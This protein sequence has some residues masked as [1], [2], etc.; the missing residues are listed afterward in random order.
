MP[1]M[2]MKIAKANGKNVEVNWC[3]KGKTSFY[4]HSL[5]KKVY[6]AIQWKKWD[7]VVLQGSS[8][9]MLKDSITYTEKTLPGLNKIYSSIQEN[10]PKTKVVFF[11]T[12][13]YRKGYSKYPYSNTH[14]KMIRRISSKYKS[15]STEFNAMLAPVGLV[16]ENLYFK[17][18]IKALYKPDNGHP[19]KLG[20]Y[21][22]ACS[23]YTTI[24]KHKVIHTP[25]A[26]LKIPHHNR[27]E[28]LV[29]KIIHNQKS[30]THEILRPTV[31]N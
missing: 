13:A 23:F 26:Y 6:R 2:F 31:F 11:M 8:R 27:I 29:W 18:K 10:H 4:R 1:R 9:D 15:L 24:F 19:S 12:W 3:V 21:A 5:R 28:Y 30:L 16:F 20:S 25:Q 22:A 14:Y 17:Y 7:F